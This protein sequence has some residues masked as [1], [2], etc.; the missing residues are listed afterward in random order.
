MLASDLDVVENFCCNIICGKVVKSA[1]LWKLMAKK[2]N[3]VTATQLYGEFECTLDN[4]GR[5]MM[6]INLKKQIPATAKNKF[7]VVRGF[8]KHLTIYPFNEWTK[9]SEQLAKLNQFVPQ[10]REFIRAFTSGSTIVEIDATGRVLVPKRLADE[11]GAIKDITLVA[12]INKIELW[13][14]EEYQKLYKNK[15][16]DFSKLAQ[17]VMGNVDFSNPS[18]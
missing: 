15:P 2:E 3:I 10:N 18:I 6:P 11:I 16:A 12:M 4:K 9:I 13:A 5:L 1:N 8:E 7:M 14:S 17:D